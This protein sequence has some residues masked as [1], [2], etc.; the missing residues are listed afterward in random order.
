MTLRTNCDY[1]LTVARVIYERLD[2]RHVCDFHSPCNP[3]FLTLVVNRN[4]VHTW[5][6]LFRQTLVETELFL[7]LTKQT[8]A[9]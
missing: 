1:S 2:W 4:L 8:G 3:N 6:I 5:N 7:F 9:S